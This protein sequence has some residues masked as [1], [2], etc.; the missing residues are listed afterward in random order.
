[1]IVESTVCIYAWPLVL[2]IVLCLQCPLAVSVIEML[3]HN[4]SHVTKTDVVYC[5]QGQIP[6]LWQLVHICRHFEGHDPLS[7]ALIPMRVPAELNG[8]LVFQ[9]NN[10]RLPLTGNRT[11]QL[12]H[13][14]ENSACNTG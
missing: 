4:L 10:I 12:A 3:L 14:S 13:L 2:A 7:Q 11:V 5:H 8:K 1:M 9:K 6:A